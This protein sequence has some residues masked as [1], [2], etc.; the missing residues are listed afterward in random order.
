MEGKQEVTDEPEA[1]PVDHTID[2]LRYMMARLDR[3]QPEKRLPTI[4]TPEVAKAALDFG[5]EMGS[6]FMIM[7]WTP[8]GVRYEQIPEEVFYGTE[9][10]MG[11]SVPEGVERH[12]IT[13]PQWMR[14]AGY[15]VDES[16]DDNSRGGN[17]GGNGSEDT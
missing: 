17:I 1:P 6:A 3:P 5:V 4:L 9:N 8:E 2:A 13:R 10:D 15:K 12:W 14:L 11:A 16:E 7:K